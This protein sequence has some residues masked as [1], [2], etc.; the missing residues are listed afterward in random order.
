MS[1]AQQYTQPKKILKIFG[2]GMAAELAHTAGV[3]STLAHGAYLAHVTKGAHSMTGYEERRDAWCKA[4]GLKRS[5]AH[6][7]RVLKWLPN[8][9]H[10]DHFDHTQVYYYPPMKIHILVTEPYYTADVPLESLRAFA[11]SV[12]GE[13]NFAT[14]DVNR[15]LWYP[16][17]CST[18]LISGTHLYTEFLNYF[19]ARLPEHTQ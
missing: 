11:A 9:R 17:A 7:T 8:Y 4:T 18:L 19:A 2:N 1:H 16:G 13:F 14:G 10:I 3:D 6:H 5:T 12:G 15:G